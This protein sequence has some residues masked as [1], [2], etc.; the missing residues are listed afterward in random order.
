MRPALRLCSSLLLMMVT[1]L[2]DL[3]LDGIHWVIV[4][5]ESGPGA[6]PMNPGW[7]SDIR[8]QCQKA[9]VPFF[10]KQWGGTNKKKAGRLLDGRTHDQM[11]T[12]RR[13]SLRQATP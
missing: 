12:V 6:R 10:F 3:N 8:N 1:I 9:E 13:Y 7:V 4:G 5:G 11:P 2:M